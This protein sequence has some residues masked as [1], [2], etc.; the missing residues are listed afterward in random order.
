MYLLVGFM[1]RWIQFN[2]FFHKERKLGVCYVLC[3]TRY[4]NKLTTHTSQ[5]IPENLYVRFLDL[6]IRKN[7]NNNIVKPQSDDPP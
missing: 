3:I 7:I 1:I 6:S 2:H 5:R 4:V